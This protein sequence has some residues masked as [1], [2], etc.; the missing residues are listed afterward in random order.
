MPLSQVSRTRILPYT[1][2]SGYRTT[3]DTYLTVAPYFRTVSGSFTHSVSA[4]NGKQVTVSES[5]PSWNTR[6]SGH[7]KGDI[8]GPFVTTKTECRG[9]PAIV[10][11]GGADGT[12]KPF[13]VYS[14]VGPLFPLQPSNMVFPPSAASSQTQLN[15]FGAEAI[16]R[17]SPAN[18][19]SS[20]TTFFGELIGEGLP[21]TIGASLK[22][23]G[24]MTHRQRRKALAKE[25]LNYQFG[26]L[27]FVSDLR[28]MANALLHANKIMSDFER[29]SGRITRR[30]YS[31][32]PVETKSFK[33][34]SS[35]AH[36][37]GATAGALY[38]SPSV[39]GQVVRTDT[40]SIQKWFSGAF[41]YYVPPPDS[42]RNE[43][44]R[45]V[46][47]SRKLLGLDLTPD[48]VW[49]LAPWS[50]LV[51]WFSNAGSVIQNW[52]DWAIDNQ[53]LLYGYM[54]EHSLSSY[55]YTYTGPT[56]FKT[57]SP[58]P[59]D[60]TLVNETKQRQQATPYGFGASYE[61]LSSRQKSILAALGIS[62][63]K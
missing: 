12:V 55:T 35:Q 25:H 43:I 56:G 61:G 6:K 27:P 22:E 16:A 44:A 4:L 13:T 45:G 9:D 31:F 23:L 51:D 59:T 30:K 52:S 7:F 8:G 14:Y 3:Q 21:K 57:E 1:G 15:A 36:P 29:G 32:P 54:M 47:F 11:L 10:A 46:I 63:W 39:Y 60:F 41:T 58:R 38:K 49:N 53:V 42:L 28:S 37:Y 48:S 40:I 62:K 50:W 24:Q 17:C 5:H 34:V 18:P 20:V 26:W 19:T 33:V 2:A